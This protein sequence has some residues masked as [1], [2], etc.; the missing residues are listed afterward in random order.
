MR[1]LH[2]PE[3]GEGGGEGDEEA[4]EAAEAQEAWGLGWEP[5]LTT[6]TWQPLPD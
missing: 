1:D 4:E 6:Y 5:F 3:G 2:P